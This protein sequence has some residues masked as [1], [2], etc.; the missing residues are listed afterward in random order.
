M[1]KRAQILK[2]APLTVGATR[3]KR[4]GGLEGP[5]GSAQCCSEHAVPLQCAHCS[6]HADVAT[7]AS[8]TAS[9]LQWRCPRGFLRRCHSMPCRRGQRAGGKE[10]AWRSAPTWP[11]RGR[12]AG[13]GECGASPL[14]GR[15]AR[16][17]APATPRAAP[18]DCCPSCRR[19]AL[20]GDTPAC[21]SGARPGP[22]ACVVLA[23]ALIQDA[24]M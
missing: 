14:A 22:P 8:R 13:T 7:T 1:C 23:H 3:P 24:E 11:A 20:C 17:G 16:A 21:A 2:A 15:L 5:L 19:R 18:G 10:V 9:G 6:M 4:R 12:A